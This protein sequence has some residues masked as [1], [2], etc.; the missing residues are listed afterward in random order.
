METKLEPFLL[1][2]PEAAPRLEA[3]PV[4]LP[5]LEQPRSRW[6]LALTGMAILGF[7]FPALWALWLISVLFDRGSGLG[8]AGVAVGV[9]GFGLFGV[10]VARELRSLAAL[11]RV[12]ELRAELSSGETERVAAAARRWVDALP[13]HAA[14]KPA[15]A[16]ADAPQSILALLRAGPALELREGTDRLGRVAAFQTAA[17]VAATPSPTLDALTVG[18]R[19]VRLVREIATLHGMRPG[20]LGTLLLLQRTALAAA[21]VAGTELAVNAAAHAII[22]HP[23]LRHVIGEVAGA[24]V[25]ARRM[26]VLAR[27]AAAAC[28]PLPPA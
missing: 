2:E 3:L 1:L 15:L 26:I 17:I 25:A 7:G 19:G 14:L 4:V 24:G 10:G 22:S 16:A 5:T 13:Q 20:F 9:A 28:S 11:R 23:L 18:W 6:S 12:D 27:A 8:W 21:T